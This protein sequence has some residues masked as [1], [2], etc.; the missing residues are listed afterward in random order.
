VVT[1]SGIID[2]AVADAAFTLKEG[3]TSKPVKGSFG[4]VIVQASKIEPATQQAY[5]QA[6]PQIKQKM[7][8]DRARQQLGD[9]RDKI[10]D[11]RAAG[12]TLAE[13]AKKLN[14]TATTIDAI[15]RSGR[16]SAGHPV[17]NLP[18]GVD[19]IGSVF[20]SDVGVDNEP[21]QMQ[22]GGWLWYDIVGITPSHE[23]KL[24]DVKAE[25]ETRW[26]NDEI[27]A[28]LKTKA[29]AMLEKLKA[30]GKLAEVAQA[31]NLKVETAAELRRG[32]PKAPVSSAALDAI[33]RAAKGTAGT[34]E[35]GAPTHRIVF[36]VTDVVD[37]PLDAKSREAEQTADTLVRGYADD[38]LG[39]YVARLETEIG[40]QINQ[41]ALQQVVGGSANR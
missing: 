30:G 34:A 27:A 37:P 17:L 5:E 1:K 35:G 12:S 19:V 38:I 6:A 25:V 22:G 15:D 23:R 13:T 18:K 20:A 10:E 9:L 4:T 28:R 39:E 16:D 31:D 32:Q 33:F 2:P 40:V 7:A 21:L 29:D 8:L 41:T 26:R 24:D 36:V 11:E 14:L 3:E